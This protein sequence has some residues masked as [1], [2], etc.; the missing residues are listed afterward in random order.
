MN[1]VV[2][3]TAVNSVFP[4]IA[5][6]IS[7][8]TVSL[9]CVWQQQHSGTTWLWVPLCAVS[10]DKLEEIN[11]RGIAM[12]DGLIGPCKN[13][14]SLSSEVTRR[15]CR[16]A[17][18]TMQ[19]AAQFQSILPPTHR[20]SLQSGQAASVLRRCKPAEAHSNKRDACVHRRLFHH[21]DTKMMSRR[22][23]NPIKIS[24]HSVALNNTPKT[25]TCL[26]SLC[27][28]RGTTCF[29]APLLFYSHLMMSHRIS[30][31]LPLFLK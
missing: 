2:V 9:G 7:S 15:L 20:M 30:A 12:G 24:H 29:C 18:V 26:P 14:L 23:P 28:R 13:S 21:T 16:P 19:P 6:I 4:L 8:R 1:H 11:I 31:L 22:R 27:I 17:P 10:I 3:I 5:F 25:P